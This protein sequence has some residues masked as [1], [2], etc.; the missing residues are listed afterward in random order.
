MNQLITV[1]DKIL[2]EWRELSEPE[3][4]SIALKN[5]GMELSSIEMDMINAVKTLLVVD[6]PW[7]DPFIF[8]NIVDAVNGDPVIPEILTKPSIGKIVNAVRFM[9]DI[10]KVDFHDNIWRYIAAVAINDEFI[11]L[12]P[13]L[14]TANKYIPEV[15]PELKKRL[16]EIIPEILKTPDS[17]DIQ[18]TAEGIQVMKILDAFI[19]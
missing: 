6:T 15:D 9:N 11:Y 2:P 7:E 10:R 5:H 18:E 13:P 8:E 1:L 14:S 17:Y 16:R 4:I 19:S 12:P 3:T